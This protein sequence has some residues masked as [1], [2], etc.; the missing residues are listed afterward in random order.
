MS[1]TN[2]EVE[3]RLVREWQ[4]TKRLPLLE[5]MKVAYRPMIEEFV[6]R[7]SG[8]GL[9]SEDVKQMAEQLFQE[10]I[11]SYPC[12]DEAPRLSEWVLENLRTLGKVVQNRLG[13]VESQRHPHY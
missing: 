2:R 6:T 7:F 13:Q 3:L 12:S 10:A 8:H 1:E 9:R 4:D 5:M 11:T